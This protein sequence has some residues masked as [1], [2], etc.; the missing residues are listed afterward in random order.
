MLKPDSSILV[1][2]LGGTKTIIALASGNRENVQLEN[3]RTFPSREADSLEH[4]LNRYLTALGVSPTHAVIAVAGPVFDKQARITNLPWDVDSVA[5]ARTFGFERVTLLNDLEAMAWSIPS[6]APAEIE[7][8]QNKRAEH[9]GTIA[10]LAPGTGLGV[11]FLTWN[12]ASYEARATE[13]GHADFAPC[14]AEQARLLTFLREKCGHVSVERVCSGLGLANIY[15][16][17]LQDSSDLEVGP[18]Q[19][20]LENA[21]D[22]TPVI[23]AAA[24]SKES[25]LCERAVSM[26]IEALAAEA[27]S[28]A[29]RVKATSGVYLGGG[30]SIH[31][32]PFLQSDAFLRRFADKGRFSNFLQSLPI[33]V[34][35]DHLSVVR[36]AARVGMRQI[37]DTTNTEGCV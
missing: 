19:A 35:R 7:V 34:L 25:P 9:G 13:G 22:V 5:I 20:A 27:G 3:I 23:I 11:A 1:V 16:F 17:L 36:G 37:I 10:L 31:L 32:L 24:L 2:D 4:L 15:R 28:L 29:L 26:F 12:G 14:N 18:V 8:L 21:D 30:L 6:A 33:A